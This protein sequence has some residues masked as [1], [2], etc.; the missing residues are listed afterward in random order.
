M[1]NAVVKRTR[2]PDKG[3]EIVIALQEATLFAHR[4]D[5]FRQDL[6]EV[7]IQYATPVFSAQLVIA[8]SFKRF[9]KFSYWRKYDPEGKG[10]PGDYL[11]PCEPDKLIDSYGQAKQDIY[12]V[13][14]RVVNWLSS[15]EDLIHLVGYY[16]NPDINVNA[17]DSW[18]ADSQPFAIINYAAAK[19]FKSIG[20][21][22]IAKTTMDEAVAL[23]K[24]IQINEVEAEAR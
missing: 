13:A 22:D 20:Q 5:F 2:R 15:T 24:D 16:A 12:Y 3:D 9:R 11:K 8:S 18:L 7:P 4:F 10:V 19:I 17:F 1:V 21:L 14:G 23:L 6:R